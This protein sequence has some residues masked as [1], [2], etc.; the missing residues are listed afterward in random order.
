MARPYR[1]I[2]EN[3][4]YHITSRGDGRRNIYKKEKDYIRFLDYV[5]RAKDRFQFRLYAYVLMTNHYHLL[6]LDLP[7]EN[8]A[9]CN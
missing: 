7:P 5:M 6:I 1:I 2:G 8:S 9:T 4:F 3:E